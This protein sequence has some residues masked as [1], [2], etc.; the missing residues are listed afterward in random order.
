M[1]TVPT[2][3]GAKTVTPSTGT[4]VAA[5]SLVS[6]TCD[7]GALSGGVDTFSF[8]CHNPSFTA[9]GNPSCSGIQIA[10]IIM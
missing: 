1:C 5:Y 8:S 7:T 6:A 10:M 9:F 2:V 3:T 4:R